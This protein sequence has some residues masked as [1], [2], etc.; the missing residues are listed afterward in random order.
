MESE[1]AQV[2]DPELQLEK[3]DSKS[4]CFRKQRTITE[5]SNPKRASGKSRR[6]ASFLRRAIRKVMGCPDSWKVDMK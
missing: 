6:E 1:R 4:V 5:L 2:A 3:S